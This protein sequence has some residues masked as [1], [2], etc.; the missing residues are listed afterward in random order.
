MRRLSPVSNN[1][2][3]TEHFADGEESDELSSS[4]TNNSPSLLVHVADGGDKFIRLNGVDGGGSGVDKRLGVL[5]RVDE[6][7]EV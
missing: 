5:Q 7:S 3:A 1:L 2:E 6:R 4:D